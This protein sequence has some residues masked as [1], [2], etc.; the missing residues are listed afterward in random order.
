MTFFIYHV[1]VSIIVGIIFG[2]LIDLDHK[3]PPRQNLQCALS[4]DM[5]DCSHMP[6][7]GILHDLRIW[8]LSVCA[9][10]AYTIHLIMDDI[11]TFT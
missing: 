10:V 11:I 5:K 6:Q 2:A 7:R 8:G 4:L 9:V 3:G 1:L